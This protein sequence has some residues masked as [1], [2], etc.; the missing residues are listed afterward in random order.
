MHAI[1]FGRPSPA[2]V[3]ALIALFVALGG[4]GY[5]ASQLGG[6]AAS[7]AKKA[8][9]H[10]KSTSDSAQDIKLIKQQAKKLRGPK[11]NTGAPGSPGSA[12]AAGAAGTARAYGLVSQL[13]VLDPTI[14]KNVTGVTNPGAGTFCIALAAGIDI[15]TTRPNATLSDE[16]DTGASLFIHT[17]GGPDC[18]AGQLEVS[19]VDESDSGGAV[20]TTFHETSTNEG[21]FF[22][23]P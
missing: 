3:V 14:R 20:G 23:I 9:K 19:T 11:G 7:T 4:T 17:N 15:S 16:S 1:R 12:G 6:P 18:P 13:G 2:M 10:K 22:S 8:K 21:F 5:A